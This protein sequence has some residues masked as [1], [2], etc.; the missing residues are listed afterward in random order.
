MA[1]PRYIYGGNTGVSYARMKSSQALANRLR[2]ALA[3]SRPKTLGDGIHDV[4]RSIAYVIA[5]SRANK[6]GEQGRAG[7]DKMVQ[8]ALRSLFLG[9]GAQQGQE[10]PAP[11]I[12]A[13]A[14][15]AP[16]FGANLQS[17]ID[18]ASGK[19]GVDA[20]TLSTLAQLESGGDVNAKN[21]NSSA[22]GP[23]QFI[24]STAAQYGLENPFDPMQSADAA[25]RL[26]RDNTQGLQQTL[27]REPNMGEIYLAHQQGLG[28]ARQLLQ[29]PNARA[30]DVVGADAVR[31]N[32]GT[33]DMTAGQFAQLWMSRAQGAMPQAP[34]TGLQAQAEPAQ[35][36]MS[37]SMIQA[38]SNPF[39][40]NEQ[41]AMLMAHYQFQQRQAQTADNRAY[42]QNQWQQRRQAGMQD[43]QQKQEYLRANPMP[44]QPTNAIQNFE[45][46]QEN[47][48]FAQQQLQ[49]RQAGAPSVSV[50]NNAPLP[51]PGYSKLDKG[52]AYR[53]DPDGQI[54]I[55]EQGL[56]TAMPIPGGPA[57][58]GLQQQE[59]AAADRQAVKE[60]YSNVVL[61][62]IGRARDLIK[63]DG[64]IGS[65]GVAGY[66]LSGI[67]GTDAHQ[68]NRFIDT[69]KAN[70]GFDRLQAMRDA[71]PTGGALGQV[72]EK[73]LMYLQAAIGSLDQ[74]QN[75]KELLHNLDR[76]KNIYNEIIYGPKA[77]SDRQTQPGG[78]AEQWQNL[79]NGIRIRRR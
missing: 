4:G 58:K 45:Y 66:A 7:G 33:P 73:E 60:R 57:A 43:W 70:A 79:G 48:A 71:S 15:N 62:D 9:Q 36:G 69:I 75:E 21:P 39:V 40:S 27:G 53:R 20:N 41:K 18:A 49:M 50:N 56:P 37:E 47:P 78:K 12:E 51:V 23:F 28:G 16:R 30:V 46:G 2:Q 59:A 34:Q 76:V 8:A 55:N 44:Q 35:G 61:E 22:S 24:K 14:P 29:N 74:S 26:T 11:P 31:L 68:L 10:A 67:P 54:L 63:N 3:G 19:Y 6:L 38:L 25:A 77:Q 42:E 72:S 5:N 13:P 1:L 65:T 17:A 32:G 52:Y 64:L